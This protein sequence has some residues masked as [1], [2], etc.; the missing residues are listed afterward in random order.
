MGSG[1][2]K[3]VAEDVT[4]RSTNRLSLT[5]ITIGFKIKGLLKGGNNAEPNTP[6]VLGRTGRNQCGGRN[7]LVSRQLFRMPLRNYVVLRRAAKE[8]AVQRLAAAISPDSF[9]TVWPRV[10]V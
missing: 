6:T 8:D 5:E 7:T 9:S 2:G 4:R 10:A 1:Q 3:T